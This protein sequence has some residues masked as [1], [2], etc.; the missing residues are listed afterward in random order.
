MSNLSLVLP[1]F[2]MFPLKSTLEN[3][4]FAYHHSTYSMQ[5]SNTEEV[6]AV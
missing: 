2:F 5:V 4:L 3:S 6:Q 1:V